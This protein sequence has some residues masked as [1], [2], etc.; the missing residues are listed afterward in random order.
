MVVAT[1]AA[2]AGVATVVLLILTYFEVTVAGGSLLFMRESKFFI[3]SVNVGEK[4]QIPF[5]TQV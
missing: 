5:K 2:T 4:G 1:A 3:V